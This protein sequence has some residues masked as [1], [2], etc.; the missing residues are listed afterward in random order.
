MSEIKR[1]AIYAARQCQSVGAFPVFVSPVPSTTY[2]NVVLFDQ[3]VQLVSTIGT[4]IP[5]A[6][7]I[8]ASTQWLRADTPTLRQ[9]TAGWTD[10]RF[11]NPERRFSV[12]VTGTNPVYQQLAAI[13]GTRKTH[14]DDLLWGPNTGVWN[15]GGTATDLV[16]GSVVS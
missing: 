4:L 11:P 16:G 1:Q 7:G 2:T 12:A 15:T 13:F 5:G 14:A 6:Y 8:D 10:G 9:P 3:V